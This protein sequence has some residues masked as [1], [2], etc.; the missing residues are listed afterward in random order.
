MATDTRIKAD[1]INNLLGVQPLAFCV[2]I[3]LIEVSH[4][5]SQIGVS[6][7]FNRLRLSESHKQ[8][9]DI[10][11]DSAFLQKF[12]K[13]VCRLYQTSILHIGANDN[14]ARIQIVIQS[15]ALTQK[16]W[17]EDN[18]VA[19]I[20][21]AD[22]CCEANRNRGLYHH[23]CFRVILNYQF[24]HGFYC[25]GIKKVLLWIVVC[26]C[27]NYHKIGVTICFLCVKRCS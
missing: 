22:T 19:V 16:L 11:L 8:S 27:S 4:A 24:N 17:A 6:K 10:L 12:C 1:T 7:Q 23:N 20:F 21:F 18:I 13:S 9:V 14:A 3:Q 2:G 25:A 26:R 15:L 5:Q